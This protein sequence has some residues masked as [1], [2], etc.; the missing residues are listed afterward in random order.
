MTSTQ[1][2]AEII[3]ILNQGPRLIAEASQRAPN[4]NEAYLIV[5]GAMARALAGALLMKRAADDALFAVSVTD[6]LRQPL[7]RG[8]IGHSVA[9]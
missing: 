3:D 2:R 4:L 5:H 1:S 7:H 9:L 8:E 6:A